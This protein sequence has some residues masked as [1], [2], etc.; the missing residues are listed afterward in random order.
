MPEDLQPLIDQFRAANVQLE[1]KLAALEAKSS[2]TDQ[3]LVDLKAEIANS[4]RMAAG[5]S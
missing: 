4:V 5:K 2:L 1:A 3:Q